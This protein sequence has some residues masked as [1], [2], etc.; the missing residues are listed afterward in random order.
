MKHDNLLY[1]SFLVYEAL[2]KSGGCD[3]NTGSNYVQ[4]F[5][6]RD[7]GYLDGVVTFTE[8][9][10]KIMLSTT[11]GGYISDINFGVNNDN[12]CF[13][14]HFSYRSGVWLNNRTAQFIYNYV[15][16]LSPPIY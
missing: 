7:N 13:L 11:K 3:V 14:G 5:F 15:N 1:Y 2:P 8:S 6:K 12:V 16:L 10:N 4:Y 9:S